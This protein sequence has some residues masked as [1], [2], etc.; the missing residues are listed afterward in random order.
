M[1]EKRNMV[2]IVC[3]TGC[4]MEVGFEDNGQLS[5]K[6]NSCK[7]GAAYAQAEFTN[8]VRTLTTTVKVENGK[9]PVVPVKSQKPLPKDLLFD[10]MECINKVRI[11]APVAIGE[12]VVE[13]IL[14]TG[15]NI[16]AAAN[17]PE[18]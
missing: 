9:N 14:G 4:N 1:K 6:G 5:I 15:I 12:I 16:I 7:R 3:P 18:R 8:P 2:C 13:D 10:C 11:K 17:M